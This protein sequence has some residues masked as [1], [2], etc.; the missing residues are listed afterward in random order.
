VFVRRVLGEREAIAAALFLA[1]APL[2]VTYGQEARTYALT[3]LIAIVCTDLFVRVA[4]EPTQRLQ[5]AYVVAAGLLLYSHLYGVFVLAAHQ[6]A[7]AAALVGRSTPKPKLPLRRWIIVS[8]AIA[9]LYSPWVPI[10]LGWV[11]AVGVSFWVKRV[12]WD[13]A[14]RAY[15][16]L[17]GST[18][19][20]VI[21]IALLVLGTK[22]IWR[23]HR[24]ALP[25]LAALTLLPV[26]V[27]VA[28]SVMGRPSFAPRYAIVACVGLYPLLAA[29]VAAIPVAAAR[30]A[31]LIVIAALGIHALHGEA[32]IVPKSPWRDAIAYVQQH[33]APIDRVAIH[34]G[35]KKRM[36]DFYNRRPLH[37][38]GFDTESLPVVP[39]LDPPGR[40]VWFLR[41][42]EW[43][44][45]RNQ[46]RH[47]PWYVVSHKWFDDILVMEL[48]DDFPPGHPASAPASRPAEEPETSR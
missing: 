18:P 31:L 7:Y 37:T 26:I 30:F 6:A 1:V 21:A 40:K 46:L 23:R 11:R 24:E 9:A 41:H 2:H 38:T 34:I 14:S 12:T 28:L 42:E 5:F 16:V 22:R 45:L 29:G 32:T 35:A 39:P 8:I 17:T 43:A 4:R 19:L 20:Y 25:L 44:P 3:M 10:V 13:D 33:A 27:P 48:D 15:W 36:W 47:G